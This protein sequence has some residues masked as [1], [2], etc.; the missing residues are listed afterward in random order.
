MTSLGNTAICK[1]LMAEELGSSS[2]PVQTI[3][4]AS[5]D[6]YQNDLNWVDHDT[7]HTRLRLKE[8]GHLQIVEDIEFFQGPS[9]TD[10]TKK[11]SVG[12]SGDAFVI[13]DEVNA[14]DLLTLQHGTSTGETAQTLAN[15]S[16]IA[17]NTIE[18]T[19][20]A[21]INGDATQ[22]FQTDN[23]T[24]SG[25]IDVTGDAVIDG[26]AEIGQGKIGL[27]PNQGANNVGFAK[28]NNFTSTNYALLQYNAG[29]TNLNAASGTSLTFTKGDTAKMVCKPDDDWDIH[30]N[31]HV[32][33]NL[34]F[35]DNITGTHHGTLGQIPGIAQN[36]GFAKSNFFNQTDFALAQYDTGQ[37]DLNTPAN[38]GLYIKQ[39]GVS[40]M[41]INAGTGEIDVQTNVNVD[42]DITIAGT[43]VTSTLNTLTA[44]VSSNTSNI[45]LLRGV[46]A[47]GNLVEEE[48]SITANHR[49]TTAM[50]L[51]LDAVILSL[52]SELA[53]LQGSGSVAQVK[54]FQTREMKRDANGV[55]IGY[56]I[57][58]NGFISGSTTNPNVSVGTDVH[59]DLLSP[60]SLTITPT[61][62]GNQVVCS[63][64]VSYNSQGEVGDYGFVVKRYDVGAGSETMLAQSTD[65]AGNLFAVISSPLVTSGAHNGHTTEI[66]IIDE[67]CLD[68]ATQYRL[69][70]RGTD[71][72]NTNPAS[73]WLNGPGASLEPSA[74]SPATAEG[75]L[76]SVTLTEVRA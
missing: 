49:H 31:L 57:R 29:A 53:A 63:F 20:K 71:S 70:V 64:L 65:S 51:G 35:G 9:V 33:N 69:Y 59:V 62:A 7:N 30:T 32:F 34:K 26:V 54:T 14:V 44:S 61:T 17:S 15:T 76:S 39:N 48:D 45:Q 19:G 75:M 74:T 58:K 67:N 68:V 1:R 21:A 73:F 25:T 66:R 4:R 23:L 36:V 6:I 43:S 22:G 55:H 47:D 18:I 38:A 50:I 42:G 24:V 52:Q 12:L 11:Y 8:D 41:N 72:S 16:A 5:T 27:V 10:S 56:T 28:T 13:R 60:S 40:K 3:H 37:V 2:Q 46:S